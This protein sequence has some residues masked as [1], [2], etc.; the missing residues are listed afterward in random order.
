GA[1]HHLFPLRTLLESVIDAGTLQMPGQERK[2]GFLV[3]ARKIG[4]EILLMRLLDKPSIIAGI[5]EVLRVAHGLSLQTTALQ[6]EVDQFAQSDVG[7]LA[8]M[9]TARVVQPRQGP[10]RFEQY[11]EVSLLA[12]FVHLLQARHDAVPQSSLRWVGKC[13]ALTEQARTAFRARD[14]LCQIDAKA[15]S[16]RQRIV[17]FPS[18]DQ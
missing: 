8:G 17:A 2:R 15:V 10:L 16:P 11:L 1:E 14:R 4:L 5:T 12:V 7:F 18:P 6:R 9:D 3:L 13:R